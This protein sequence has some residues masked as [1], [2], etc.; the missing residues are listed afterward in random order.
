MKL[1]I[2][3]QSFILSLSNYS[4]RPGEG[5]NLGR[6]QMGLGL[7]IEICQ[8]K[9]RR[10]RGW[11][12]WEMQSG[13][14]PLVPPTQSTRQRPYVNLAEAASG[15][16][17]GHPRMDMS[18]CDFPVNTKWIG[19]FYSNLEDL[20]AQAHALQ[21][22]SLLLWS[23]MVVEVWAAQTARDRGENTG[24]MIREMQGRGLNHTSDQSV[25]EGDTGSD[26]WKS[27]S[28]WQRTKSCRGHYWASCPL[29]TEYRL[30]AQ[31]GVLTVTQNTQQDISSTGWKTK[32]AI[33]TPN[34][35]NP[36]DNYIIQFL[37]LWGHVS[38]SLSTN[39][40]SFPNGISYARYWSYGGS[41]H[42]ISLEKWSSS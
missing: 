37:D 10:G 42:S 16:C 1:P 30:T 3:Y 19:S 13:V 38:A 14:W 40:K 35:P 5:S 34:P 41:M 8:V 20:A 31:E 36:R 17:E 11:V 22:N 25:C 23:H 7:P 24:Q 4:Y 26:L 32:H 2:A 27:L 9:I 21:M 29:Y 15:P 33:W 18:L 12:V 28:A 6:S 39:T